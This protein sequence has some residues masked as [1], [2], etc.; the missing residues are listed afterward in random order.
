M[1]VDGSYVT[2]EPEPGDVDVVIWLDEIRY[3]ELIDREDGQVL[4]LRL[5]FL[6]RQPQEAFAVAD[7]KGWNGWLDFFSLGRKR[8]VRKGL[9]EVRLK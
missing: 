8:G 2:A 7:E 4:E 9:V 5:M 3:S 6:T 1:F